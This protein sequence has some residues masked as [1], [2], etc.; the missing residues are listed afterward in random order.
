MRTVRVLLKLVGAI[1]PVMIDDKKL[2]K[3]YRD[4]DKKKENPYG[5]V[6]KVRL[7]KF[8]WR[9]VNFFSSKYQKQKQGMKENERR[10]DLG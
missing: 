2:S 4:E 8:L 7:L 5:I 3:S 10:G 1:H 6:L 9:A